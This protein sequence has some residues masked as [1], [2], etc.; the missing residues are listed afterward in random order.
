MSSDERIARQVGA[1]LRRLRTQR[2]K[3]QQQVAAVAG[4]PAATLAAYESGQQHPDAQ[5]LRQVLAALR[6]SP[7]EF[8]RCCGPWGIAGDWILR[9]TVTPAA[10]R[11]DG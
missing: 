7:A 2:R 5:A 4:I 3:T 6:V 10:T 8:G 1:A 11:E 9:I